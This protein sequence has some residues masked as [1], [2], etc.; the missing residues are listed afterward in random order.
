[1]ETNNKDKKIGVF[2]YE[3]LGTAFIMYALIIGNG[4]FGYA[5]AAV[6]FAMMCI[7]YNVSGGHFNPAISVGMFVAN[8]QFGQ[9]LFP[10]LLMVG[11]QF[12]GAFFGIL[13]GF[14]AVIASEY[15]SEQ[16]DVGYS[17]HANVPDSWVSF[18]AFLPLQANRKDYDTGISYDSDKDEYLNDDW[19]RDWQ[20]FWAILMCSIILVLTF[21][22][23]KH[24]DTQLT[25]N[26]LIQILAI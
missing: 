19:T 7:A 15:Q 16:T 11:A 24:K 3:F 12:A 9:D 22:S 5:A 14:F 18:T 26:G 1:M 17:K 13:L 2:V 21:I 8:K 25:D 10:L 4:S 23:I 6:T 20:C